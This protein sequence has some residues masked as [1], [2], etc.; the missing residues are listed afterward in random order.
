MWWGGG[1][2]PKGISLKFHE[3]GPGWENRKLGG[4]I[5]TPYFL[6]FFTNRPM[7]FKASSISA[8]DVA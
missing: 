6:Y 4:V 1:E 7:R 5:N 3:G 8:R 2:I